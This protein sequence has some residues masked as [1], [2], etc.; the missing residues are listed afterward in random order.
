MSDRVLTENLLRR[1]ISDL[2]K[3][4]T[5]CRLTQRVFNVYAFYLN[6]KDEYMPSV[7]KIRS[8]VPV[9]AKSVF[10]MG[11][12]RPLKWKKTG[13]GIEIIIPESVR[14]NPPCDLV[15]GV[16]LKIK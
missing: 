13:D 14:K 3:S 1:H 11:H 2:R 4:V 7:V 8:F 10:L 6:A 12:N 16:K 15:W 5:G 9:S